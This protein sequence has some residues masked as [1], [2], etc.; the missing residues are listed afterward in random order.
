MEQYIC[1]MF[2]YGSTGVW[3]KDGSMCEE[4]IP[5]SPGLI[6][7]IQ[8]WMNAYEKDA[9]KLF[10]FD[11]KASLTPEESRQKEQYEK[12]CHRHFLRGAYVAALLKEQLPSWNIVLYEEYDDA[13][14]RTLEMQ[15]KHYTIPCGFTGV[16]LGAYPD[17]TDMEPS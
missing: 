9:N 4:D 14:I 6:A 1:V 15:G 7:K 11:T 2:D 12:I 5:V 8:Q 16:L 3:T 13:L 10:M 17:I